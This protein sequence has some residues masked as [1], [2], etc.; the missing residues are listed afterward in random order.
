MLF[1]V[2]GC[3]VL[4]WASRGANGQDT[5]L[6]FI[7]ICLACLSW[8]IDNNMTRDISHLN[9]LFTASIK[10]LAAGTANLTLGYFLGEKIFLNLQLA[11]AS[12]LGFLG[13][14]VSLVAFIVSLGK[15]GTA[16]T[17]ALFSTAPFIGSV[18]AVAFLKEP[19]TIPFLM[20]LVLMACGVWFHISEDHIHEHTHDYLVHEHEHIHDE[21]HQHLHQDGT[22]SN[23]LIPHTHLHTHEKLT[24]KHPHFPDIHHQHSH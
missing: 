19:L 24:H 14:G 23:S 4:S 8:G 12:L 3:L 11:Q 22:L 15:I 17:G 5:I 1:I 6:G 13:I 9:P 2:T 16:R 18:L 20:A 7:L 10:G 21:H